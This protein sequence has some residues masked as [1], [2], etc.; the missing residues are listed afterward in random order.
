[1]HAGGD[2]ADVI[3]AFERAAND[4]SHDASLR[5]IEFVSTSAH[6]HRGSVELRLVIDKPGGVDIETCER[7]SRKLGAALDRFGDAFTLSVESAGLERPLIRPADYERF[8]GS[9]VKL[10]TGITIRGAK[11]HRGRLAGLRGTNVIL[12]QPEGELPLPLELIKHANIE[13]DVRADLT[14][15]KRERRKHR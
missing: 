6:R 11:T 5:E 1:M 15:E 14:R 10:T 7:I 3:G 12:T 13:Y 4:L 2:Y 9:N 8:A